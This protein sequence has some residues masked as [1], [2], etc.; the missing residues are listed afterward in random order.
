MADDDD[1]DGDDD[2]DDDV[3]LYI[4]VNVYNI[5]LQELPLKWQTG[6]RF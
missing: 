6:K 4:D 5:Y 3:T 2:D 1:D